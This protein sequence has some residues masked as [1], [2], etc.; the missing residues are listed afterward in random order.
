[1][2]TVGSG[3]RCVREACAS[4]AYINHFVPAGAS[5]CGP[6]HR[7]EA[8][9]A[10]TITSGS[11]LCCVVP[12]LAA[13]VK[14]RA[15]A[16]SLWHPHVYLTT[17]RRNKRRKSIIHTLPLPLVI[18]FFPWCVHLHVGRIKLHMRSAFAGNL[19]VWRESVIER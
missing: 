11:G 8:F 12:Q 9:A 2:R 10:G 1:M 18:Y 5:I 4:V 3:L 17:S 19:S 7:L 14:L 15:V 6:L 16:S 13:V